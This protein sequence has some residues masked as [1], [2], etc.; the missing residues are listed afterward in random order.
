MP[1]SIARWFLSAFPTFLLPFSHGA[2]FF[3]LLKQLS[4]L[5]MPGN[6]ALT[7]LFDLEFSPKPLCRDAF[8]SS[9]LISNTTLSLNDLF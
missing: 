1:L 6:S 4:V 3:L 8:L 5:L 9:C 2:V 7:I